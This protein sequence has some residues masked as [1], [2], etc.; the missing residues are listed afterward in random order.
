MVRTWDW[1]VITTS[2]LQTWLC[3]LKNWKEDDKS[4][5]ASS[6]DQ[7]IGGNSAVKPTAVGGAVD[8]SYEVV[9]DVENL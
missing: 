1:Y 2:S 4:E 8:D 5:T 6:V 7:E 3:S 9:S